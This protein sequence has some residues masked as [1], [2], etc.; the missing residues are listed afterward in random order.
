[1]DIGKRELYSPDGVLMPLTTGE[2]DLLVAFAQH[3]QRVLDRDQ[4]LDLTHGRAASAFDRAVDVQLSRLRRKIEADPAAP[5][6]IKTVR[7]GG[8][9]FTP[10]VER[11]GA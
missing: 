3:P 1:M 5:Q 11:R 9:Q 7:G 2:F 6:M 8:Y 10:T 4:L